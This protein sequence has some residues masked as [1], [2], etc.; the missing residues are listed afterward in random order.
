M[1][2]GVEKHSTES[3]KEHDDA[4]PHEDK[5]A[6]VLVRRRCGNAEDEGQTAKYVGQE[7]DH[8]L[9]HILS[10]GAHAAVAEIQPVYYDAAGPQE[11]P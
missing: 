7:P 3:E 4:Q 8:W 10:Q 11:T 9:M 6:L 2:D 1:G 5:L